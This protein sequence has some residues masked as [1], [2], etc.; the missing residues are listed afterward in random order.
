MLHLR[1]LNA[2]LCNVNMDL[3]EQW[4]TEQ[5]QLF[6]IKSFEYQRAQKFR[7]LFQIFECQEHSESPA[8]VP[9]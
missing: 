5:L 2:R 8:L 4:K 3:A 9:N 6:E 7:I 1:M